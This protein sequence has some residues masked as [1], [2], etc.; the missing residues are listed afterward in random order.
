MSTTERKRIIDHIFTHPEIPEELRQQFERWMLAREHDS[1]VDDILQDIWEHHVAPVS[2]EDDRRGLERLRASLR[3]NR[4][5]VLRRRLLRYAG[6]AA[7]I[8]IVFVGGYFAATQ[9][10]SPD[11]EITLLTAKGNVGEFLLPDGTKVWLNGESQLKYNAAFSGKS[12][13]VALTGEAFFEVRKDSLRP[14]RVGM[15]DLQ[16]EVLGTSFDAMSYSF[17]S[18]EEVVLKTGSVKISGEHLPRPVMLRPNERFLLNQ[19]SKRAYVEKVDARNYTQ[20]FSPRLVFDNTA[21]KDLVINLERR[22]NIEISLSS[23]I[24]PEKRLSLVI[25]HE[26]LEDIMEVISSLMSTNYHIDGNRV[27]ITRK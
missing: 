24:S 26:P 5:G 7:A 11:K 16:I 17:G 14:F 13:D 21:L 18:N 3:K 20:W 1:E 15:N 22:Y 4:V 10:L 27:L 6:V 19:L 12:R 2:E 8:V 23:N 9:T 25:C